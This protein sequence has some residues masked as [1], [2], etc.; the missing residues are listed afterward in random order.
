MDM[1]PLES[2][3]ELTAPC[4]DF[5][6]VQSIC[7]GKI[8][9]DIT[10]LRFRNPDVFIAGQLHLHSEVWEKIASLSTY[11]RADEVLDWIKNKVSLFKFFRPFKGHFK[12]R[13]YDSVIP[14]ALNLIITNLVI[15]LLILLSTR[16]LKGC[17][18]ALY[19]S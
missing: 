10:T 16:C 2:E 1:W 3:V 15:I 17:V 5:G 13:A 8:V 7:S 19:Q 12:G 18:V 9:P 14:P 6:F 11:D 4:F